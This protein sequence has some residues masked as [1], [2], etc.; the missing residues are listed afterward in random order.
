MILLPNLTV[1]ALANHLK[2]SLLRISSLSPAKQGPERARAAHLARAI[3]RSSDAAA[4]N[5]ETWVPSML[6]AALELSYEIIWEDFVRATNGRLTM[7][8]VATESIARAVK[9]FGVAKVLPL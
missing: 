3:H 1:K 7:S 5:A 4:T 8:S 2:D 6:D 9:A